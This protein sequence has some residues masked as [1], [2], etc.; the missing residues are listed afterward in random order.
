MHTST[1]IEGIQTKGPLRPVGHQIA[2]L[3]EIRC[4]AAVLP[5]ATY[6]TV[7]DQ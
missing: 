6:S 7:G 1:D 4:M 5:L 2:T 3:N